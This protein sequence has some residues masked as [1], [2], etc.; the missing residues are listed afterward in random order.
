MLDNAPKGPIRFC[1][2]DNSGDGY[3]DQYGA[4]R[5]PWLA[6]C[7]P[8]GSY[9]VFPSSKATLLLWLW[10]LLAVAGDVCL[11][12]G[13]LYSWAEKGVRPRQDEDTS[14]HI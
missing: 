5:D 14:L 13:L 9:L 6:S 4:E 10:W 8:Q 12:T 2:C 7:P 3:L 1:V 11:R